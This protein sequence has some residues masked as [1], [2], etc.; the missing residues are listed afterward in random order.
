MGSAC[1]CYVDVGVDVYYWIYKLLLTGNG[2]VPN[3]ILADI[4][5]HSQLTWINVKL[6]IKKTNC[7]PKSAINFGIPF[8]PKEGKML[9]AACTISI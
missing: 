4:L 3:T 8:E 1:E 2:S 6:N 9:S 5:V 7:M